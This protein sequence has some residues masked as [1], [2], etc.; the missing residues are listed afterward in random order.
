MRPPLRCV[1]FLGRDQRPPLLIA[2]QVE[3]LVQHLRGLQVVH[4][5]V[6]HQCARAW[7]V[8]LAFGHILLVTRSVRAVLGHTVLRQCAKHRGTASPPEK[9]LPL[10]PG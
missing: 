1:Q 5:A 4:P 8:R 3:E 9:Q 10:L 6:F 7:G 2:L